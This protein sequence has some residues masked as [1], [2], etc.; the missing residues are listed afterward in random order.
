[1][2]I[3]VAAG[4]AA[5]GTAIGVGPGAG[6]LAGAALCNL[7][8]PSDGA[9]IRTEGPRLGDPTITSSAYGAS[10]AYL[11]GLAGL[12]AIPLSHSTSA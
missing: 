1:M 3:L 12:P 9:D 8:F 7:Q 4:G 10:I 5:L 11:E 6:W 2:A